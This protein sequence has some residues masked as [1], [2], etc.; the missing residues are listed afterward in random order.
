[1]NA[2][3]ELLRVAKELYS[4]AERRETPSERRKWILEIVKHEPAG[5][6]AYGGKSK[7]SKKRRSFE[8][9]SKEALKEYLHEHPDANRSLHWVRRSPGSYPRTR[10]EL[11][12]PQQKKNLTPEKH[13]IDHA[14]V[15][16]RF[17]IHQRWT[18]DKPLSDSEWKK[19]Y[20]QIT[21]HAPKN[22][23]SDEPWYV[24][25]ALQAKL[26]R[27][28]TSE[29]TEIETRRRMAGG[30]IFSYG[31]KKAATFP[32]SVNN[33]E[34]T[35]LIVVGSKTMPQGLAYSYRNRKG[36]LELDALATSGQVKGMGTYLIAKTIKE[37]L[38]DGQTFK[39]SAVET[40]DGFYEKIG[41]IQGKENQHGGHDW[42][43]PYNQAMKFS[44]DVLTTL[45]ES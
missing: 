44:N 29:E 32:W 23:W 14:K 45:S 2:A 41:M 34:D 19:L 39:L 33:E 40:A 16:K 13:E 30:G 15:E 25:E 12:I 26:G 22:P 4:L 17:G 31:L 11:T 9:P 38:R 3:K 10:K 27:E 24:E 43:M 28:P 8:F 42:R 1:M 7:K 37:K 35:H 36:E 20:K 5:G 21:S 18:D 6:L